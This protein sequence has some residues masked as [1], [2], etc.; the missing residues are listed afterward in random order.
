MSLKIALVNPAFYDGKEF[1]NRFDDYLD[2]IKGGNLYVAPFE[3]PLGL[4]YLSSALKE[5]GHEVRL[6]DM[7]GLL[8]DSEEL[9]RQLRE[10]SP[11]LVGIT[12]MTPTLPEAFKVAETSKRVAPKTVTVLGGVHPTL[13]PEGALSN[14]S[15]DYVIRGEGELAIRDLARA[16]ERGA[17]PE[18]IDGVSYKRNGLF[19]S[20]PKA[21][22]IEDLDAL[23]L[24]DYAAFPAAK[25]IEHN[26]HLRNIKGISMLIGR[27]CPF[28]CSFCAVNQT[29]GRKWRSR[30]PEKVVR[31]ILDLKRDYGIEGVWFKDSIFNLNK[32]WTREFAQRLIESGANVKFQALTRIDMIDEEEILLLKKAGLTQL[33]LGIEA[34]S[35][36]IL[37]KLSKGITP[38]KIKRNVAIAKR[39]VK[40]F[41]FFM[42]GIPGEREEDVQ[43]TFSLAKELELDRWTWSIYSP[44]PGSALFDEL[45]RHGKISPKQSDYANIHFT[46]AFEGI[47]DVPSAR[48]KELY[49][50]INDH[51]CRRSAK[52]PQL[53]AAGE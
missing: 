33:D 35:L 38:E 48:L 2:W 8:M 43:E 52:E 49:A 18:S 41:G 15:V 4:A 32:A 44:L 12:A 50:E 23:P 22:L 47:C 9:E 36:R 19:Y 20:R 3:P 14:H 28:N 10:F 5:D 25:Y 24:A 29:M 39:H 37:Q 13:D 42:I 17:P 16:I 21:K 11:S 26:A 1:R 6:I 30:S 34:G 45:V 46:K 7:Q 27:G 53:A 31:Q 51:F 40:V